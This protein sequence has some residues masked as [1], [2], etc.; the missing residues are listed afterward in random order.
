M[1]KKQW[2]YAPSKQKHSTKIPDKEKQQIKEKGD[3]LIESYLKPHYIKPPPEDLQ[4]NYLVDIFSKWYRHYFYFCSKYNSPVP[5]AISQSFEMKF[6][7][8]EYIGKDQFNLAYMRHTEQW[9]E[10]YQELSLDVCLDS[11]KDGAHF[12]P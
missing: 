11:I 7:R 9:F 1:A 3:A 6:A 2:V 10:L 4:C 12:T 5:H 8:L